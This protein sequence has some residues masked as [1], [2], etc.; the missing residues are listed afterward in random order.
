MADTAPRCIFTLNRKIAKAD[1]TSYL[2][3]EDFRFRGRGDGSGTGKKEESTMRASVIRTV[4][5]LAAISFA[6]SGAVGADRM[7]MVEHFTATW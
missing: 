4:V 5:V 2:R 1:Q 3:R 6:A 7:V